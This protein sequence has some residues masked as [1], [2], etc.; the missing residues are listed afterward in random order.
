MSD[1]FILI[2]LIVI[3]I[4]IVYIFIEKYAFFN[5]INKLSSKDNLLDENLFIKYSSIKNKLENDD[6]YLI[7]HAF[8]NN[9]KESMYSSVIDNI[10]TDSN[11]IIELIT[12]D[13]RKTKLKFNFNKLKNIYT[14]IKIKEQ[15]NDLNSSY[16]KIILFY[17]GLLF[18]KD[19]IKFIENDFTGKTIIYKLNLNNK[20]INHYLQ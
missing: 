9:I 13:I 4:I 7:L 16:V 14:I 17:D 12:N 18:N 3:L 15:V 8:L 1:I 11:Q 19:K 2:I 5:K 6:D 10:I 20:I